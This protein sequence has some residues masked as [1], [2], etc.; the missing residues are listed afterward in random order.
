MD[1]IEILRLVENHL[2]FK[3]S[4]GQ[5]RDQVYGRSVFFKVCKDKTN[6][7]LEEI[8]QIFDKH[9]ATVLHSINNVFSTL[10]ANAPEYVTIYNRVVASE[11]YIPIELRYEKLMKKNKRLEEEIE[12]FS[13]VPNKKYN[14]LLNLIYEIPEAQIDSTEVKLDALVSIIKKIK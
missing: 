10:D 8:G 4:Q 11:E 13:R 2:G 14:N 5:T 6:M 9:H 1:Y 12:S 7:S 3:L